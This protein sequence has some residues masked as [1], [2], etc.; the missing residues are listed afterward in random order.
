MSDENPFRTRINATVNHVE[1]EVT[2]YE[3]E[4]AV[5]E[6]KKALDAV[7]EKDKFLKAVS[8]EQG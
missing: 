8:R 6:F 4:H 2:A 5:E 1:I 7:K 3:A